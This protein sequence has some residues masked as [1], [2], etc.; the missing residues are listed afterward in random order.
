MRVRV[1]VIVVHDAEDL[2]GAAFRVPFFIRLGVPDFNIAVDCLVSLQLFNE[3]G[4]EHDCLQMKKPRGLKPRGRT[5]K[6]LVPQ[7]T[8]FPKIPSPVLWEV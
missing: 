4:N 6:E 2:A 5:R 7:R 3:F 1:V 8:G